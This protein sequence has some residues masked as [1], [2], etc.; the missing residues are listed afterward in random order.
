MRTDCILKLSKLQ[1]FELNTLVRKETNGHVEGKPPGSDTYVVD[2]SFGVFTRQ[3]ARSSS[4]FCFKS[5]IAGTLT[6]FRGK[7]AALGCLWDIENVLRCFV[8]AWNFALFAEV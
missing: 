8:I 6:P 7:R 3:E 4:S 1:I 2:N 5:M